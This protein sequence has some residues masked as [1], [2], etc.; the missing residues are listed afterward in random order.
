VTYVCRSARVG[1]MLG[2]PLSIRAMAVL[3]SEYLE[4]RYLPERPKFR[5]IG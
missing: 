1:L 3:L 5:V 4:S 2:I